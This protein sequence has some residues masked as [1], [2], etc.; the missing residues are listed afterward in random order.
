M[1]SATISFETYQGKEAIHLQSGV[2]HLEDLSLKNGTIEVDINFS[3][4]RN[5]PGIGFRVQDFYNYERFYVRPHQSGNPDANQYTPVFNGTAGWQLYYGPE[6]ATAVKYT[7]DQW[8]HLKIVMKEDQAEIFL[9]D[10]QVPMLEVNKLLREPE[11]GSV[12]L[13]TGFAPVYFANF[14]YSSMAE[15]NKAQEASTKPEEGSIVNWQISDLTEDT[16]WVNKFNLDRKLKSTLKWTK[17]TSEDKGFINLSRYAQRSDGKNTMVARVVVTS[18]QDQIKKLVFGFSDFVKVY[19]NDRILYEGAD[20]FL[21]RD[22]RFLGTVG[23]FD[24]LF[25]PLKKGENELWFVVSENFGGWGGK[26]KFDNMEGI[27]IN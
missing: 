6:Y 27:A 16:I 4:A 5:F 12:S 8:H 9:D 7:F 13:N 23:Y 1:D 25:L 3:Q 11:A 20:N 2:I 24:A 22:Y 10:L 21:S 17:Q 26:A 15:I 19:L 14:Q 18:D